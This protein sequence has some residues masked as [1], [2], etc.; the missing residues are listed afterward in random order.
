MHCTITVGLLYSKSLVRRY[1]NMLLCLYVSVGVKPHDFRQRAVSWRL[2]VVCNWKILLIQDR[3]FQKQLMSY[4]N[5]TNLPTNIFCFNFL[6]FAARLLCLQTETCGW[7][8]ISGNYLWCVDNLRGSLLV[9]QSGH[10]F[11]A[12]IA[13]EGRVARLFDH[14]KAAEKCPDSSLLDQMKLLLR[15]GVTTH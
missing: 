12:K 4:R 3:L 15:R 11:P 6:L 13:L 9:T 7:T 2:L 8:S 14:N 1:S 5:C 10:V